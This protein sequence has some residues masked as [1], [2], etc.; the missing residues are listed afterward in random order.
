MFM[1]PE[2]AKEDLLFFLI[3]VPLFVV[4]IILSFLFLVRETG[5]NRRVL[6]YETTRLASDLSEMVDRSGGED[7]RK[8]RPDVL[9][10]GIYGPSGVVFRY[11]T[12]PEAFPERDR[13]AQ[14]TEF[15]YRDSSLVLY[16]VLGLPLMQSMGQGM[17]RGMMNRM[18]GMMRDD[19]RGEFPPSANGRRERFLYLEIGIGE[20]RMR[21]LP[22]KI[23]LVFTPLAFAGILAGVTM[24]YRRNRHYRLREEQ[25][26]ELIS[27][28]EAARTLTHEIKNPLG[29]IRIQTAT[30]RRLLPEEYHRNLTVIGEEVDRLSLLV[31]RVGD[32]LRNAKGEPVPIDIEAF[33][34]DLLP[35]FSGPVEYKGGGAGVRVLFDPHRLR[36][37]LENLVRNAIES[38]DGRDG[39][40]VEVEVRSDRKR[41]EILVM[42][43]GS[44]L[45]EGAGGKIFDPFFTTKIHGSGIGLAV[46]K[47]FVETMGG[48][49]EVLPRSGG[50]TTARMVLPREAET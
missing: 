19:P 34:G 22:L 27:L 10:F 45:P 13:E 15:V 39:P 16:R 31:D 2:R 14:R 3:V 4:L 49:L 8:L 37:V 25:N 9:G 48:S 46:S 24:L 42:D 11:G 38:L 44:G 33:I 28:G 29:A 41:A 17:G 6:E 32:F 47:R 7:V 21:Q 5:Y 18:R 36:T 35:R 20:W 1:L 23:G 26:R 12:A 40:A 30:L 50:G 43:R